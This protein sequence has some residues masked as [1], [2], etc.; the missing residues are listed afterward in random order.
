MEVTLDRHQEGPV[1]AGASDDVTALRFI[2]GMALP[3]GSFHGQIGGEPERRRQLSRLLRDPGPPP[4]QAESCRWGQ[5]TA[6][7][8]ARP[9]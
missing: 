5:P 7:G 6:R 4:P 3:L 9:A 1:G 2:T 8:T